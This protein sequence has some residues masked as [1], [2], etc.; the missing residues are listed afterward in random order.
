M[1][2]GRA[3]RKKQPL[4]EAALYEY[5]IGAL[6]RRMR[7]VAEL[8][9]LMRNRVEEGEGGEAKISAVIARLKEQRYLN[10]TSFATEYARLRQ[11]NS[12]FGK[13]RVRQDLVQKG[14]HA[15]VIARTLDSAYEGVNEEELARQHLARKRV[16]KP[17]NEKE[18]ARVMRMLVRAGFSSG[19]IFKI[20]KQWEL[21]DE[22][23][24]ALDSMEED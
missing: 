5:A 12:S 9:R 6:G 10:D 11:E 14:V 7:T 23:L 1:P 19:T 22:A 4:D 17:G 18:A 2:L 3:P 21:N 8:K 16:R 15:D 13:R 24:S 20:L